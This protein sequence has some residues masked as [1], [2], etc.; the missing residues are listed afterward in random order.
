MNNINIIPRQIFELSHLFDLYNFDL[1]LV[2][3]SIRDCILG[4]IPDDFDFTTRAKTKDILDILKDYKTFRSGEKYGT[5][6]VL[7]RGIKCEITTFRLDGIYIDNRHPNKVVFHNDLYTDLKRRDFTINAIAYDLKNKILIDKFDCIKDI[8]SKIIK[9]IGDGNERFKEDSLRIL[10]ALSFCSKLDFD[11]SNDTLQAIINS[12][13]L[14][15]NI[16]IE[17]IRAEITKIFSGKNPK[18]A[19]D[20][21]KKY[22]ILNTKHI[23]ANINNINA[24]YRIY[25]SFLIFDSLIYLH[26]KIS[27]KTLEIKSIFIKIIQKKH[28]K[29]VRFILANLL[30]NHKIEDI[31]IAL[32]LKIALNKKYR[33]YKRVFNHIGKITHIDGHKLLNLG[34]DKMQIKQIKQELLIQ[35]ITNKIKDKNILFKIAMKLNLS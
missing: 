10:R 29:E 26:P 27:I 35:A 21:M 28:I 32:H 30:L 20:L 33:I 11:I 23:P 4:K 7:F 6:G 19:F 18:K 31:Y 22:N 13:E 3:G 25:A 12:K 17:R 2:G 24:K 15:K 9:C 34:F 1:Y 14:L 8:D 16:K 5:I